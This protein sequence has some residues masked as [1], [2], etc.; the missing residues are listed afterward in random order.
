MRRIKL[1]RFLSS[2]SN[3]LPAKHPIKGT[4]EFQPFFVFGSG[5]NG[6]T[7]LNRILNQHSKL[8]LPSE[9]NFLGQSIIKYK[10]YNFL[11]WRDLMKVIGGELYVEDGVHT[12]DKFDRRVLSDL[13]Y[14]KERSLQKAIDHVYRS[15]FSD[16]SKVYWGDTTPQ[17]SRYIK[18]ISSVFPQ[19]KYVFLVRHPLDVVAS[20]KSGTAEAFGDL[21]KVENA[22]SFWK[23]TVKIYNNMKDSSNL[24]LVRYE[25]LVNDPSNYLKALTE[26]LG[27]DFEDRMLS[28]PSATFSSALHQEPQHSNLKKNI[29][30]SSVGNWKS[31]LSPQEVDHINRILEKEKILMGY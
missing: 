13:I 18:E 2:L 23:Q 27:V 20:Y 30:T 29:F 12:W 21:V 15:T 14:L 1:A 17:N 11:N 4:L 8:S 3:I 31:V 5:R 22:A 6:S 10:L 9:Q 28:Y 26:F 7:L 25:D 19:A 16:T 24:M